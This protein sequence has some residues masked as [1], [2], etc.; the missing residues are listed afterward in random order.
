M[1][2]AK[3]EATEAKRKADELL[4]PYKE[5]FS[6]GMK[7]AVEAAMKLMIQNCTHRNIT[8]EGRIHCALSDV[9]QYNLC[10]RCGCDYLADKEEYIQK[11]VSSQ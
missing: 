11:Y 5:G 4:E 3:R 10:E 8:E 2:A 7:A 9:T 1:V 6:N